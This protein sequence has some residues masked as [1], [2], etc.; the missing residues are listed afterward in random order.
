MPSADSSRTTLRVDEVGSD[1]R[2]PR[3]VLRGEPSDVRAFAQ[4]LY[5]VVVLDVADM[6]DDDRRAPSSVSSM[7]PSPWTAK[8]FAWDDAFALRNASGDVVAMVS[9]QLVTI[10]NDD[11]SEAIDLT[12][13]AGS[14]PRLFAWNALCARSWHGLTADDSFPEVSL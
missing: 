3:V 9:G 1:A 12:V 11:L 10:W 14:D 13:P 6:L 2:G 5:A 4:H 7:A 8:G